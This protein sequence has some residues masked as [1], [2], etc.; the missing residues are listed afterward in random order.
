MSSPAQNGSDP[1]NTSSA[2]ERSSQGM[3]DSKNLPLPMER[4]LN[5]ATTS[6]PQFKASNSSP[7]HNDM[8]EVKARAQRMKRILEGHKV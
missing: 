3:K 5:D 7:E 4:Y 6:V 2:P 1:N 8:A